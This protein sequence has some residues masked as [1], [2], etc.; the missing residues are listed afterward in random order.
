MED[1]SKEKNQIERKEGTE[2]VFQLID[3]VNQSGKRV[4][5]IIT[6]IVT[7]S[8]L[9]FASLWNS[10]D[11]SWKQKRID[12]LENLN[13]YVERFGGDN[14]IKELRDLPNKEYPEFIQEKLAGL[15][16]V[17]KKDITKKEEIE[18]LEEIEKKLSNSIKYFEPEKNGKKVMDDLLSAYKKLDEEQIKTFKIPFF[19]AVFD[20][21]DL[22]LIGG[23]SFSI[24]LLILLYSLNRENEN[25]CI[26]RKYISGAF[27]DIR[28]RE[29]FYNLISMSQL[30]SAAL[31][32][33][34]GIKGDSVGFRG[35]LKKYFPKFLFFLPLLLFII[36]FSYDLISI[37]IGLRISIPK[38]II[39]IGTSLFFL[40]VISI[41]SILCLNASK[42]TDDFWEKISAEIEGCDSK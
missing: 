31:L 40:V 7:A 2:V 9:A 30:L 24:S 12:M 39:L 17:K 33:S 34:G 29:K 27:E 15:K 19:M 38:T 4:R 6:V 13:F 28:E 25:L 3:A 10:M 21:N 8:I 22:G 20:I 18:E 37:P 26:V 41:F 11:F 32:P 35:F 5:F 1:I 42:R 23:F 36:I 16:N 14:F